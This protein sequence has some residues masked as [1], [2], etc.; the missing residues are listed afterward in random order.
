MCIDIRSALGYDLY[1]HPRD[2]IPS[3]V[4]QKK[5]ELQW[6]MYYRHDKYTL[7]LCFNVSVWGLSQLN[8]KKFFI[9]IH[10]QMRDEQYSVFITLFL[11]V[12]SSCW[13]IR[14]RGYVTKILLEMKL[15]CR[16]RTNAQTIGIH[17]GE[18]NIE[19][20][21]GAFSISGL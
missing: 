14:K 4:L 20:L 7:L 2:G 16:W 10:M 5:K 1:T 17:H 3:M 9:Y 13:S 11:S 18:I 15:N 21:T 19:V 12:K 6:K 8:L